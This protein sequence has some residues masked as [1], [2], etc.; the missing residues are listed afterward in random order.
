MPEEEQKIWMHYVDTY[1]IKSQRKMVE[2]M[3]S[4]LHLVYKSELP[5]CYKIFL[6]YSLGWEMLDNQKRSGVPNYYEYHYANNYPAE[7]NR[8]IKLTL[9]ALLNEQANLIKELDTQRNI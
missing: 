8:Y 7:F 6:D 1:K 3:R 9:E 5:T 2:I 4:N